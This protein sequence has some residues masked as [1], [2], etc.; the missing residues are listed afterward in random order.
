MNENDKLS[1]LID[2]GASET[3]RN[4]SNFCQSV[5]KGR[6]NTSD[7]YFPIN[8]ENVKRAWDGGRGKGWGGF[9]LGRSKLKSFFFF[10]CIPPACTTRTS[11]RWRRQKRRSLMDSQIKI[12][13][14]FIFFFVE[15][16]IIFR[17]VSVSNLQFLSYFSDGEFPGIFLFM[18]T[19]PLP[20]LFFDFVQS[21]HS[22]VLFNF[23]LSSKCFKR[24]AESF[25]QL[26][27][28]SVIDEEMFL[29]CKQPR[30]LLPRMTSPSLWKLLPRSNC[31]N[32]NNLLHFNGS[33]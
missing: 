15:K 8:H 31:A 18:I 13:V 14:F 26:R 20:K 30:K 17:H 12:Y 3:L 28:V 1:S 29:T 4:Y 2:E 7:F 19:Q 33:C 5:R 32:F 24:N 21:P 11:K 6:R 25:P 22:K 9:L 16:R 10:L 23:M 27:C